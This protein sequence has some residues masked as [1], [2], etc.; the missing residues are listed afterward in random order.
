MCA[1]KIGI[2]YCAALGEAEVH[3]WGTEDGLIRAAAFIFF[4]G[5]WDN[6]TATEADVPLFPP[7]LA[8]FSTW[9]W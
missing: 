1:A 8:C 3:L 7:P 5:F 2:K 9:S 6:L 4:I